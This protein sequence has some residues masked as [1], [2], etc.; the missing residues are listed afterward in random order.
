MIDYKR[1]KSIAMH[2]TGITH[3]KAEFHTLATPQAG[4]CYIITM[5]NPTAHIASLSHA[6]AMTDPECLRQTFHTVSREGK[7]KVRITLEGGHPGIPDTGNDIRT[8]LRS[9]PKARVEIKDLRNKK[10]H[11]QL[12]C[13]IDARSGE[14]SRHLRMIGKEENGILKTVDILLENE[15]DVD[16]VIQLD[17]KLHQRHLPLATQKRVTP[18]AQGYNGLDE[19]PV[20]EALAQLPQGTRAVS[21]SNDRKSRER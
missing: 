14:I 16:R 17:T 18:L 10:N 19:A 4:A 11:Y 15:L 21:V 2:E 7:D 13:A 20:V 8:V 12:A 9:L 3:A 1:I 5:Y 6:D